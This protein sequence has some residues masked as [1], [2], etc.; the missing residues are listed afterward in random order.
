M[1]FQW[2]NFI[3]K[4]ITL[5]IDRNRNFISNPSGKPSDSRHHN[6]SYQ[7]SRGL[8]LRSLGLVYFIAFL[9]L[10]IQIHGLIGSLGILPLQNTLAK[11][12]QH[13]GNIEAIWNFPTLFWINNSDLFIHVICCG[14]LLFSIAVICFPYIAPFWLFL[15]GLYLSL[16]TPGLDFLSFQWDVL[17]LESGFLALFTVSWKKNRW[18]NPPPTPRLISFSYRWL[19]FRLMFGSGVVKLTSG[20]ASWLDL[21]ALNYHYFTQPLPNP[22]SWYFHHLPKTIHTFSIMALFTIELIIP[23]FIFGS[24]LPRL[25]AGITFLFFQTLII[26]TGNY[27]FFNLLTSFLC[28]WLI[29]DNS[30]PSLLK[31]KFPQTSQ[32]PSS[33]WV[34]KLQILFVAIIL[35]FSALH[36]SR[37]TFK[38]KFIWPAIV[39]NLYRSI[40]Q[41]YIINTYGLFQTM[42]TKRPEIV[43]EG[44]LDGKNWTAYE[45]RYK[46]GNPL[47]RPPFVVPHQPRLD[48]QMWFAALGNPRQHR[49]FLRFCICLLDGSPPVLN[50]LAFNPFPNKPPSFLRASVYD[51]RFTTPKE[52]KNSQSW[53][54]QKF[55]RFYLPIIKK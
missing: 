19:L 43:L 13:F 39:T 41:F 40:S 38:L 31:K 35:L 8:F 55:L 27:A 37:S 53:W 10:W 32:L 24:R 42:T 52:K 12:Q 44:S 33:P 2:L 17:L 21:T 6:L 51:Y 28:L 49:W 25:L 46:P 50:L 15:W 34:Q 47:R 7:T 1:Q 36:F 29:D 20:D 45:F 4:N 22:I 26:L 48:W 16:V 23:F 14:G 11:I 3:P 9:S 54:T 5:Q 30:W 18:K